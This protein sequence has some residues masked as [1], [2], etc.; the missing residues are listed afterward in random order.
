M[1]HLPYRFIS[2]LLRGKVVEHNAFHWIEN[3]ADD[4]W[5]FS[6]TGWALGCL[7]RRN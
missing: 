4:K 2:R 5:P 3:V 6:M 1:Y 7:L